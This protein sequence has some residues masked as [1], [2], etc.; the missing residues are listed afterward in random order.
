MARLLTY[1]LLLALIPL[2]VIGYIAYDS[3]RQNIVN[4]VK[5]HLE[6]VAILKEQELQNWV[7]DLKHM[8][9]WLA[10]SP[11]VSNNAAILATYTAS[12]PQYSAA[13]DSLVAEFRRIAVLEEVSPVFL[14]DR[15]SG[16]VIASSDSAWEGKLRED[17]RYFLEGKSR[18]YVSDIYHSLSLGQPVMAISTPVKDGAGQ[19]LGVLAAHANLERLSELMLERSGLGETGETFLVNK[20]NLL[21]TNTVFAPDGALKK[22]IFGEGA[23]W[24]LE[25][26]SGVG[27]FIDYRGE[28]VIG[29]YQWLEDRKLAL[30]AKQDQ[31]EALAPINR[32]WNTIAVVAG[33]VFI[34]V[35][36]ISVLLARQITNPLS[37]LAEYARGIGKGEYTAEVE[38]KGKDEVASVASHV[39][40]MVRQILATQEQLVRHEK[41]V[42][43]GQLAGGVGHEL[44]NPLGA[45]KNAAYF[46]NMALEEPEPEVKEM[47]DVLEREVATS[48]R[49]ISSLLEFARPKPPTQRKVNVNDVLQEALSRITVPENIEVISQPDKSLPKILA[50]PDQLAQVFANIILNGIQAMPKGGRLMVK[51]EIPSAGWVA[52][53]VTDTGA[54]IPEE[55]LGK[56]FEPLFTTKA[57]GIGLGL[58]FTSTL[59][60][61]NGGT[62]EVQ[63]EVGKGSTFTVKLP[64]GGGKKK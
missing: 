14:L 40:T 18:I 36:G 56:L 63:S 19:L 24:A 2:A 7:E 57:K 32:L 60:E 3:G 38:I 33:L 26:K 30:I 48:E 41:L 6:S 45:I 1:F 39:K 43:L 54:G 53:S 4:Q 8:M 61:G 13:H 64:I 29:A 34:L 31:T 42:T 59:V 16:Q 23:K 50:D 49:I 25:G 37:K 12:D 52:I 20:S 21:I 11:Q 46:L 15:T 51:S 62:I 28:P 35:V 47:L 27:L 58:A 5:A 10:A 17:R 9:T 22:W 55:N 44:R